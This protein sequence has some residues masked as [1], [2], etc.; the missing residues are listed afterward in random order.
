[1]MTRESAQLCGTGTA[2][3][4]VL[5]FLLVMIVL[6]GCKYTYRVVDA[7]MHFGPVL[8]HPMVDVGVDTGEE[9]K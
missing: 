7:P 3:G 6:S 4:I 2:F 1:M 5:L 8:L 9:K